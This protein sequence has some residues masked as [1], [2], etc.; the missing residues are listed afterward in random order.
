MDFETRLR[1]EAGLELEHQRRGASSPAP[2]PSL[3]P[4][5]GAAVGDE[6]LD[7][8]TF[9]DELPV[10]VPA[11]LTPPGEWTNFARPQVHPLA[12]VLRASGDRSV[13]V[14]LARHTADGAHEELVSF[15]ADEL[16]NGLFSALEDYLW[17]D[18]FATVNGFMVPAK[19]QGGAHRL[20]R[21]SSY[22]PQ[23]PSACR[24]HLRR[25]SAV[26]VD[27]DC[28]RVGLSFGQ[29]L[30]HVVDM[31]DAGRIPQPSAYWRS[32]RGLWVLWLLRDRHEPGRPPPAHPKLVN[33]WKRLGRAAHGKLA[34]LG[35]DLGP[36]TNPKGFIRVP[37]STNRKAGRRAQSF[38]VLDAS[39]QPFTYTMDELAAGLGLPELP[40]R[41]PAIERAA[42]KDPRNVLQGMRGAAGRAYRALRQ[43]EYLRDSRGGFGDGMR[44]IALDLYARMLNQL[45]F[46]GQKLLESGALEDDH[47]LYPFATMRDDEWWTAMYDLADS[48]I[49]RMDNPTLHAQL[50]YRLQKRVRGLGRNQDIADKLGVTPEEHADL[51][52]LFTGKGTGEVFPVASAFADRPVPSRSTPLAM[53]ANDKRLLR[54]H[55]LRALVMAHHARNPSEFPSYRALVAELKEKGIHAVPATIGADL[56]ALGLVAPRSAAARER[57]RGAPLPFATD[58]PT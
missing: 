38:F 34:M 6:R 8:V 9:R 14:V 27:L 57:R 37:G 10:R 15:P 4:H 22:V 26:V 30:G 12:Q 49:P 52:D 29:A 20:A 13:Y 55:L 39:G 33:Y 47:D 25:L 56:R 51:H 23:L 7:L 35:A 1:R 18:G 46:T 54:R 44:G 40:A 41:V 45:R 2:A 58:V 24:E 17:E 32:G 21:R 36:S 11:D 16:E 50:K 53:D 31:A 28:D 5:P 48:F 43:V 42:A 19:K 3:H